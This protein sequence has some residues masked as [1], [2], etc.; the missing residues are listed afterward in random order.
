MN[1]L[2]KTQPTHCID[3]DLQIIGLNLKHLAS[4]TAEKQNVTDRPGPVSDLG[5]LAK[6]NFALL[7][8]MFDFS[9]DFLILCS[10]SHWFASDSYCFASG[11]TLVIKL[12]PDPKGQK[13]FT[14]LR[15]LIQV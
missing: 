9:R 15:A 10:D 2:T 7:T 5:N 12:R 11:F 13:I 8:L 3:R 14:L 4:E 1:L 6:I